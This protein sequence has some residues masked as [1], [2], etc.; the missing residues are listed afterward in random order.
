MGAAWAGNSCEACFCQ[1]LCGMP[2]GSSCSVLRLPS[3]IPPP[4]LAYSPSCFS[5]LWRHE[6]D[7]RWRY[8]AQLPE[9]RCGSARD[10]LCN[11][12]EWGMCVTVTAHAGFT[13]FHVRAPAVHDIECADACKKSALAGVMWGFMEGG[14]ICL[15]AGNASL[16]AAR[17]SSAWL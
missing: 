8:A 15:A 6:G 2:N 7:G 13:F 10:A 16:S 14:V 5:L 11:P 17:V 9:M 1:V 4:W 3:C 12:M